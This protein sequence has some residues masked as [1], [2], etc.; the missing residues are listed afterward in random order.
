MNVETAS[1]INTQ[2]VLV[3]LSSSV[4]QEWLQFDPDRNT[5]VVKKLG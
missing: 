5:V 1:R 3:L 4:C 2:E